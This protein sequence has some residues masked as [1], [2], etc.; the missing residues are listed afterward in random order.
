MNGLESIYYSIFNQRNDSCLTCDA[1]PSPQTFYSLL[2]G[3]G[4]FCIFHTWLLPT[5][6]CSYF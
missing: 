5:S 3:N 4:Y 2:T 1:L 6:T